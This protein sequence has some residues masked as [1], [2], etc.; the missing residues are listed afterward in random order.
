MQI[1]TDIS[2]P[3]IA[4]CAKLPV[5]LVRDH[6][7][8]SLIYLTKPAGKSYIIKRGY[9]RLAYTDPGGRLWSRMLLAKG[10]LDG[11]MPFRA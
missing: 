7:S 1:E 8:R 10:T 3:F 4:A 11:G 2:A 5:A 9:V 6:K